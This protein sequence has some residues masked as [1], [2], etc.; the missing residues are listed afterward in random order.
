MMT[1]QPSAANTSA[2]ARPMPFEPPV[3]SAVLPAI[4]R[5]M[6][7]PREDR[8]R[9]CE[10]CGAQAFAATPQWTSL[11]RGD[12]AANALAMVHLRAKAEVARGGI[13]I[14]Q[15]TRRFRLRDIDFELHR[16]PGGRTGGR[17]IV[18]RHA[19]G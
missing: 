11:R 2:V 19:L 6:D 10:L 7:A 5:S 12:H 15:P 16:P 18:R 1:L 13:D 14:H 17:N 4:F 8:R 3:I 9:E